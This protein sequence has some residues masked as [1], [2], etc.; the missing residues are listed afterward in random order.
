MHRT[1][2]KLRI[3]SFI[4]ALTW[5]VAATVAQDSTAWSLQRCLDVA[6]QNSPRLQASRQTMAGAMAASNETAASR[7]P[8]LGVS[9]AYSYTSKKQEMNLPSFQLPIPGFTFYNDKLY[10]VSATVRTPIYAGGSLVE[11]ARASLSAA[12]AVHYDLAADSLGLIYNVRRAY[13]NALGADS[14]LTAARNSVAR[15]QRNLQTVVDAQ[16]IG[17]NSEENRITA[18]SRLR[19][20][21]ELV[22]N[23][24]NQARAAR[25]MLG[26][27]VLQ[28]GVEITP[29]EDL[30]KTLVDTAALANVPFETHSEIA[31]ANARIEQSRH[32]ARASSGSYLPSLSGTA[33]YHYAKPG[34]DVTQNRWMD[35]YTVGLSA[36]WT[37][38][39]WKARCYRVQQA[40]ANRSALEARKQDLLTSLQTRYQVAVDALAAASA[41]RDKAAEHADLERQ[42]LTMVEGRLKLGAATETEFLDAQDDLT[43]AET[44]LASTIVALR[45]AEADLLNASGY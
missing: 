21:E 8:T 4:V 31:S 25:L 1:F 9:G 12:Q 23:S 44:D 3:V 22:I 24:E 33:A 42:R 41:V 20:T 37:L 15:I 38:W 27:L 7:L 5:S 11:S 13:Y 39:D 16:K 34:L 32:L 17:A 10:D 45:L 19:Q 2:L 18:L 14:R 35:Y 26:G 40:R 29:A 28:P 36:T 30:N 6:L 43:T